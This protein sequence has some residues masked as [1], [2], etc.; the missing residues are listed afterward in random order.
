MKEDSEAAGFSDWCPNRL[1]MA[2]IL[3]GW[4]ERLE[5]ERSALER[6]RLERD[7]VTRQNSDVKDLDLDLDFVMLRSSPTYTGWVNKRRPIYA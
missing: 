1:D 3:L 2:C 5:S 7:V 6:E 4:R